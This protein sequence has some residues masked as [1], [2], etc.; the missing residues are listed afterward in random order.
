MS[1]NMNFL[2][3]KD[4]PILKKGR[5]NLM[6]ISKAICLLNLFPNVFKIALYDNMLPESLF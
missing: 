6:E 1:E 4:K 3:A 5:S 2:I